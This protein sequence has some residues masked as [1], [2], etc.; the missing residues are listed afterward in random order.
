MPT[1]L[2]LSLFLCHHHTPSLLHNPLTHYNNFPSTRTGKRR[3]SNSN[4]RNPN[5]L[6]FLC[7]FSSFKSN[8][9]AQPA[10][11]GRRAL[12]ASLLTTAAS[13]CACDVAE[14]VST[15]R[16][17]LRGAKVP[18]SEFTTLPNGLKYYDLK[19][20]GGAKAEKGSR[21]AVWL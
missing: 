21:V 7:L 18:E 19:V 15:S 16:R 12:L 13:V 6:P 3:P 9:T 11:D 14:A 10:N 17:A 8:D 4:R 20:G 5:G 1:S 2:S